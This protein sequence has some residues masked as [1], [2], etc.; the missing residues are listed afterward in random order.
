[1]NERVAHRLRGAA[2]LLRQAVA[3]LRVHSGLEPLDPDE[4]HDLIEAA[5]FDYALDLLEEIDCNE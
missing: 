2:E 1:V 3:A 4:I 5:A